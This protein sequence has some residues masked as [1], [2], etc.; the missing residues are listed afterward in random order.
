MVFDAADATV[1]RQPGG[2]FGT[3][4]GAHGMRTHVLLPGEVFDTR[5]RVV[6]EQDRWDAAR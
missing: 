1:S 4:L 3:S 5:A 2:R 6:L